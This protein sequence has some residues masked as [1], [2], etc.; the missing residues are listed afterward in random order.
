MH[1]TI[2]SDLH[3]QN[4]R[5]ILITEC[6]NQTHLQIKVFVLKELIKNTKPKSNRI[7]FYFLLQIFLLFNFTANKMK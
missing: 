5:A 2:P 3:A 6:F 1:K 7:P 4:H